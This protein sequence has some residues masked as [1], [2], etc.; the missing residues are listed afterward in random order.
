MTDL[1]DTSKMEPVKVDGY[2][3]FIDHSRRLLT[4][5]FRER[6]ALDRNADGFL[7]TDGALSLMR[8]RYRLT[9]TH[10]T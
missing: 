3:R 10:Q 2:W 5:G 8:E 1:L 4:T 9:W 7:A 6:P